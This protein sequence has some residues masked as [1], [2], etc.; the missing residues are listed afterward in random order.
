MTYFHCVAKYYQIRTELVFNKKGLVDMRGE[1]E[2]E[3]IITAHQRVRY[4][5]ELANTKT[6]VTNTI[7]A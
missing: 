5:T 3:R 7:W 4:Q 6:K 2:V 1:D